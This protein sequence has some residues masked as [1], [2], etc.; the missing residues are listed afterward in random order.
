M[1]YYLT[2]LTETYDYSMTLHQISSEIIVISA[3]GEGVLFSPIFEWRKFSDPHV[4]AHLFRL[5]SRQAFVF[6][7]T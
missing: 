7:F 2:K 5:D 6:T 4:Y 1:V 3:S